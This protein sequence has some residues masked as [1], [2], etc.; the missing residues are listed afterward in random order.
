LKIGQFL[1]AS[2][3]TILLILLAYNIWNDMPVDHV[4]TIVDASNGQPL[5]GAYV[6]TEFKYSGGGFSFGHGS[7]WCIRTGGMYTA[8]DGKFT[9][10]A[11]RSANLQY[12]AIKPGYFQTHSWQYLKELSPTRTQFP[13]ETFLAPQNPLKPVFPKTPN[14]WEA[15]MRPAVEANIEFLKIAIAEMIRYGDPD[16][17]SKY[18]LDDLRHLESSPT[19]PSSIKK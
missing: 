17:T 16:G 15:S 1:F 3:F 19:L 2:F 4:G 5:A 14:C 8:A 18:V 10:R 6:M 11:P 13:D 12:W 7:T 9:F